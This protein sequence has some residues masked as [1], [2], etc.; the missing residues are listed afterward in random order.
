MQLLTSRIKQVQAKNRKVTVK[1]KK[2]T[3]TSVN[4]KSADEEEKKI[5]R[6]KMNKVNYSAMLYQKGKKFK[7]KVNNEVKCSFRPHIKAATYLDMATTVPRTHADDRSNHFR[8]SSCFR[9]H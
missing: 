9:N 6:T 1:D 3:N 4:V 7:S 5:K 8:A 2:T